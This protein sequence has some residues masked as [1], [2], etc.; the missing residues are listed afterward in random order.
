MWDIYKPFKYQKGTGDKIKPD[1]LQKKILKYKETKL[2][3][4][5]HTN[6]S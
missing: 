5:L 4:S 6:S 3:K 1:A 2:C